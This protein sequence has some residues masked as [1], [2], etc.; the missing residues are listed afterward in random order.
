MSRPK[1][2]KIHR[3]M[4]YEKNLAIQVSHDAHRQHKQA[5]KKLEIVDKQ[6]T[7]LEKLI[8]RNHFSESLT[9]AFGGKS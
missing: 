7:A 3:E 2:W 4:A 1:W 8:I 6:Q 9:R 5:I